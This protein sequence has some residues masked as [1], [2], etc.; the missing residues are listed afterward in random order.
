MVK[1]ELDQ[2]WVKLITEARSLGFKKEEIHAFF[3]ARA[4]KKDKYQEKVGK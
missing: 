4:Y 3:E 2:E 1:V